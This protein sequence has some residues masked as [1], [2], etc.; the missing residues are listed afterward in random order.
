MT[1]RPE[2]LAKLPPPAEPE[3]AAV[4]VL[5]PEVIADS[6]TKALAAGDIDAA[7]SYL[8]EDA[9]VEIIPAGPDGDGVYKGLAEI[10]GWYETIVAAKGVGTLIDCK[11]DGANLNCF[12]TY[13]DEGLKSM[14]VDFIEGDW[15]AV[16]SDGKIQSYTFT[17]TPE[18]LAKFPPP[19]EP[20]ASPEIRITTPEKIVGKWDGKNGEYVVL[21]DFQAGDTLL[22][23]VSG[24]GLISRSR[25]WF[26]DDLLKI[27]DTTGDCIG[28]VGSYE[29]YAT[30]VGEKLVMLRFVLVGDDTCSDRKN[31]LD[32]KTM[33]PH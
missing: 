9:A 10:R 27:E 33:V 7:L 30:Y 31:T 23:N 11:T 3:S 21:H 5:A 2:L 1:T 22:V 6:W 24:V 25:Y 8:A 17:I 20:T 29:V 13:A 15:K 16:I 19:P 14:G 18:S 28:T 12:N 4:E 32:G 26:E